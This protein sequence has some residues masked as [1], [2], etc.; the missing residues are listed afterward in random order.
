[1]ALSGHYAHE[2]VQKALE[3][4]QHF[5]PP[6]VAAR[7][8]LECLM[9]QLTFLGEDESIA[10]DIVRDHLHKLQNKQIKEIAKALNKSLDVIMEEVEIIKTL[11]A[12]SGQKYN[13]AQ[14]RMI[15]T[16]V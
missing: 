11:D 3:V 8:M 16:D 14:Q 4:V 10:V 6:G 15:K 2:G 13:I 7:Y 5:D 12:R 9:I 1:M